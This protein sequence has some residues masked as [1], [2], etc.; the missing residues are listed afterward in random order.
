MYERVEFH[1]AFKNVLGVLWWD[2]DTRVLHV[3]F[4]LF[5][6]D[7][8]PKADVSFLREFDGVID[9]VGQDLKNP[10]PVTMEETLRDAVFKRERHVR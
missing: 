7:A 2:S 9:K 5:A 4:D 3:E 1:E 6:C 8:I 10:V